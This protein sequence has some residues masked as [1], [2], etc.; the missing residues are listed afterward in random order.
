MIALAAF[1]LPAAYL[2]WSLIC[3]ETN[4]TRAKRIGIP[5]V[6]LPIDPL[7]ILFQ[8]FE[9]HVWALLDR[10]PLKAVLPGWTTYARRGWFFEDKAETSLR[11]G[12]IWGIVTPMG[13]YVQLNDPEAIN[14]VLS[15]RLDFQRPT[16]PYSKCQHDETSSWCVRSI[17]TRISIYSRHRTGFLNVNM[18][19]HI[20]LMY[21]RNPRSFWSM[22]LQR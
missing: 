22:H 21:G 10:L 2:I 4:Y 5:L 7:N 6:R 16:E 15:R 11:L 3:L 1:I 19:F 14:D 8:V 9:S 18:L 20:I 17:S 13:V 12:K